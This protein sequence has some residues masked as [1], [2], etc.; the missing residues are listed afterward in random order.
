MKPNICIDFDGVLTNYKG[1]KGDDLGEV[2]QG[3]KEFL[4]TLSQEY[5]I[6]IF[7]VRPFSK[8]AEWLK[9]NELKKYIWTVTSQKPPAHAYIDDRALR[10]KGNYEETLEELENFK[11]Y[12]KEE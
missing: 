5:N 6:I 4:E 3:A 12:W 9:E 10:F 11:P 1:Y 2:K 8:V 7:S